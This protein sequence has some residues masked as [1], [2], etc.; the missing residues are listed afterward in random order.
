M[1]IKRHWLLEAILTIALVSSTAFGQG[2]V[3]SHNADTTARHSDARPP[4]VEEGEAL[5]AW[6]LDV[7]IST[8]GFGLGGFYRREFT[9]D[10]FGFVSFSISES[11]DAQDNEQFDPYYQITIVPGKLNRFLVLP[12]MV[13]VQYRLFRE[14]I[15]D[16]FRP[17]VNAAVGPTMIYMSP[18]V[19][20]VA[21]GDGTYNVVPVEFFKS[22]GRGT[23]HYTGSAYVGFGANFG[24]EKSNIFGIN[25][26]YYFTYLFGNGLPSVYDTNTGLLASRK[27]D[28]G[29]FFI[30]LNVG[31]GF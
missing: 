14:D 22:L 2:H 18:F 15:V 28:F 31:L 19:D 29:G 30:T 21:N 24:G 8:G 10:V 13:G 6:G 16:T 7:L 26:R 12:L 20:L 5:T 9:P 4:D 17:Y 27:T 11:K 1:G 23:A 25:F 3:F